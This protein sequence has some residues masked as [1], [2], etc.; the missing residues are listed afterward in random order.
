L[1]GVALRGVCHSAA[2]VAHHDKLPNI[3]IDK[4]KK[5]SLNLEMGIDAKKTRFLSVISL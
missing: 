5:K 4:N 2:S 1:I 3:L